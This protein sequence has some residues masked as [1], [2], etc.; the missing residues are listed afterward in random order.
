[1]T[2]KNANSIRSAFTGMFLMVL[3]ADLLYVKTQGGWY[4]PNPFIEK[5]EVVILPAL[6][7]FGLY[8]CVKSLRSIDARKVNK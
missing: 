1:M 2:R 8:S 3:S 4:D 7:L 5:T 6:F